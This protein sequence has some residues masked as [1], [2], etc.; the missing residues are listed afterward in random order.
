MVDHWT[1]CRYTVPDESM[2]S[3]TRHDEW[4]GRRNLERPWAMSAPMGRGGVWLIAWGVLPYCVPLGTIFCIRF[5]PLSAV[6]G[7]IVVSCFLFLS[8]FGITRCNFLSGARQ[9]CSACNILC[10]FLWGVTVPVSHHTCSREN[11]PI[12]DLLGMRER[13]N[14]AASPVSRSICLA[15]ALCSQWSV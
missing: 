7:S 11:P 4:I 3:Q 1:W 15:S 9:G 10:C 12:M 14:D 2:V 6:L 5:P 13:A 8:P